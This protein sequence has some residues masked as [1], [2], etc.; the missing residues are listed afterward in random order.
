MEIAKE[1]RKERKPIE[2]GEKPEMATLSNV[3]TRCSLQLTQDEL[4]QV[5]P[6]RVRT[7]ICPRNVRHMSTAYKENILVITILSLVEH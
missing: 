5:G 4:Y 3:V 1:I 2:V 6:R 7:V